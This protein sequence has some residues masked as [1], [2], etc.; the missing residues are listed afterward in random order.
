MEAGRAEGAVEPL[1]LAIDARN[2]TTDHRGLG[3]YVRALTREFLAATDLNVVLVTGGFAPVFRR[4]ELRAVLGS[5]NFSVS[6]TM[7]KRADVAWHPWNGIFLRGTAPIVAT[8]ADAGPFVFPDED[9]HRRE[10]QQRPFR[11]AVHR[12]ARILTISK[13][14]ASDIMHY[15]GAVPQQIV[16]T[17]P[18]LEP[19]FSPNAKP[20]GSLQIKNHRYFFFVGDVREE[21]KNFDM[22]YAAYRGAWPNT[23]GPLLVVRGPHDPQLNGVVHVA[24]SGDE[25]LRSL[26]CHAV[27]T[28]VPASYE[29]F[30]LPVLESMACGTV[31]VSSNASSLPEAAG[32]AAILLSPHDVG[33]WTNAL[34]SLATDPFQYHALREEGFRQARRFTWGS[35]ARET[36]LALRAIARQVD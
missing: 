24:A 18:G 16:V 9:E 14:A 5:D 8:I 28:C 29:G 23:D 32:K 6:R 19:I 33:A 25:S 13:S 30:G 36:L 26:Y 4:S 17:Y 1:T 11:E 15:L 20:P 34:Q 12:A 10:H 2:I 7:P 22:L 21:R 35:C 31:V 3:R 27:A